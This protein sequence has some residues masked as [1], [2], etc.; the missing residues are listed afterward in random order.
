MLDKKSQD[1]CLKV[2]WGAIFLLKASHWPMLIQN[3]PNEFL[4]TIIHIRSLL[5][6]NI[7]VFI[8]NLI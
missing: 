5:L 1:E 3:V 4:P 2:I 8:V 6:D 7:E